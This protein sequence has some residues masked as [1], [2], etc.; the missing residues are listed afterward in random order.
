MSFLEKNKKKNFDQEE[1][2][3][4]H[5][6]A[7]SAKVNNCLIGLTIVFLSVEGRRQVGGTLLL[8]PDFSLFLF[9]V[10]KTKASSHVDNFGGG[11]LIGLGLSGEKYCL[12]SCFFLATKSTIVFPEIKGLP[13]AASQGRESLWNWIPFF[14]RIIV[15]IKNG[16][17]VYIYFFSAK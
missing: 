16:K 6:G 10:F 15:S 1:R 2:V 8:F 3:A 12:C 9:C 7:P 5:D 17:V 11:Y 13:L 14:N 4:L